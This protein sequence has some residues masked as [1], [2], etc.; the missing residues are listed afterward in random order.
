V[1]IRGGARTLSS[2][3]IFK[4]LH[5]RVIGEAVLADGREVGSL[6][7]GAVEI[8][9][10]LRGHCDVEMRKCYALSLSSGNF[11]SRKA[12]GRFDATPIRT[13]NFCNQLYHL[14][15]ASRRLHV[16]R[17]THSSHVWLDC[18]M[19]RVQRFTRNGPCACFRIRVASRSWTYF[20]GTINPGNNRI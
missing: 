17:P 9:L 3:I 4:H 18:Q 16:I 6:P 15:F 8:L 2:M 14:L 19:Q 11:E 12:V 13:L 10:D 5:V 20:C 1:Y 7:A